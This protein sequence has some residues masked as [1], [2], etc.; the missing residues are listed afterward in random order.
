MK[1]FLLISWLFAAVCVSVHAQDIKEYHF[2]F[3]ITDRSE[4][5]SITQI[6]SIDKV[7]KNEVYAYAL[8]HEL[9][10][11]QELGYE[12]HFL[13]KQIPKALNMATNLEEM[14]NWDRYPT[15]EVYRQMMKKFESDYPS[16]CKLDSIGTTPDGHKLYVLRVTDHIDQQEN[17]PEFFYTSTMHG[18]ETT[19]FVLMLRLIDSLLSNYQNEIEIKN[20]VNQIDLYINPNANPDGTYAGG[21][22]TVSG[23]T[24]SNGYADLNRDFP[25]PRTGANTPYQ[26]E[27]QAMIDFAEEHHFVMSAN[28]HGGEAVMNYPWDTW[29]TN[30][31]LHAD[32]EWFELVCTDYVTTAREV[33]SNYMISVELDGVTH[34][35]TW[36]KVAGGRQDYM[37]YWHQCREVTIELSVP[38]LLGTEYFNDYWNYNKQSL[39]NY[40]KESLYGIRGTVLTES[41][42][43]LDAMIRVI[44]HDEDNDSSM[45]FTDPSV[46]NYHRL[47]EPGTYNLVAYANG[48]INDTIYDIQ[49][50]QGEATI[51]NFRLISEDDSVALITNITSITD[52]LFFDELVTHELIIYNDSSAESTSYQI[53]LAYENNWISLN[54]NTGVLNESEKDTILVSIDSELLTAGVYHNSIIL[55]ASDLKIDTIPVQLFI[56]DTISIKIMPQHIKDTLWAG[57]IKDYQ[58]IIENN[59][60]LS[61]NYDISE[62]PES[63][64]LAL[65]KETGTL[66][67]TECDTITVR[68]ETSESSAGSLSCNL[69]INKV[70]STT[71]TVPVQIE[72]KDTISYEIAPGKMTD[73][74]MQDTLVE[75]KFIVQN[76]G[77]DVINYRTSIDFL[78]SSN[79]WAI[80]KNI[81]GSILKS[82]NDTIT[83]EVNTYN[84]SSGSYICNLIF[85]ELN[86]KESTLPISIQVDGIQATEKHD[87]HGVNIYPNP[88]TDNLMLSFDQDSDE[89][90]SINM[91]NTN[92]ELIF[93]KELYLIN[94]QNQIPIH[95]IFDV[96]NLPFGIYF[97]QISSNQYRNTY[98]VIKN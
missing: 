73:T 10:Q 1:Q 53:D 56:K 67:I 41:L 32:T 12:L 91:Y 11:F 54:K 93:T 69:I 59:G 78:T 26:P 98:K 31:N 72:V 96:T 84:L 29:Y 28:F 44:N 79:T 74:L 2:K 38:K 45:V 52:T 97:I 65:N 60:L 87:L 34:G 37:N 20:L 23:A 89:N 62:S 33:K 63:D 35:A 6:I 25:D 48:F 55:M 90:I 30:E 68:V 8:Q 16:I 22:H 18:D 82:S 77:R 7:S 83:I 5:D 27:T 75:Y 21:N 43:P 76:T 4:L 86:G 80:T 24:R 64:W 19:G 9:D 14:E 51:A 58:M 61:L 42:Q 50:D 13:E 36:Y 92:G 39:I 47:I 94:Q 85:S 71:D 81:S 66:A 49:V 17:E 15:Y 70:G 57:E 40:M 3:N 95:D 88:F 46:G